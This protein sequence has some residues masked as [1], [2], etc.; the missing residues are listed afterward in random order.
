MTNWTEKHKNIYGYIDENAYL[1]V[2]YKLIVKSE[3]TFRLTERQLP[4]CRTVRKTW[5]GRRDR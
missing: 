1:T 4:I 2:N 3:E 5:I